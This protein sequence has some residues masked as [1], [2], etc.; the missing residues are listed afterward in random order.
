[1]SEEIKSSTLVG[2]AGTLATAGTAA[3]TASSVVGGSA[4]TIILLKK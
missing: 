4:A 2:T 1:M 3:S